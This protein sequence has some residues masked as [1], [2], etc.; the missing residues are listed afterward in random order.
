V[1]PLQDYMVDKADAWRLSPDLR[2]RPTSKRRA[3]GR[4]SLIVPA[5]AINVGD[6]LV[7]SDSAG[8]RDMRVTCVVLGAQ[9]TDESL[10]AK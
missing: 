5:Q 2:D 1:A 9:D 6:E 7:Y 10:S 4:V 3:L 8:E